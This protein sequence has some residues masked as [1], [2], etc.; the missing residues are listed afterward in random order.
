MNG[1]EYPWLNP[2]D[3]LNEVFIGGRIRTI[4]QPCGY[5]PTLRRSSHE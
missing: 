4:L 3:P 5:L 1:S 2:L